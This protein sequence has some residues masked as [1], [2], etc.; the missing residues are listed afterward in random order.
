MEKLKRFLL[1][2]GPGILWATIA[3]GETHLVLLPY[4]GALFG[5]NVLWVVLL[6]HVFYYP[7]F[8]FGPRYAVATGESLIDG[9]GRMKLGKAFNW[10]FLALMLVTPPLMM[11]S[12]VGLTGSALYAGIPALGFNIWCTIACGVTLVIIVSRKY[13]VIERIAKLL[14]FIIVTISLFAFFTSPPSP[15]ELARGLIPNLSA[16]A[17]F[18][19]VLV[20]V[21][22]MPTDPTVSIFLSKWAQE[23]RREWGDDKHVLLNSLNKS[24]TD[25]RTG[26]VISFGVAVVFLAL[27]ATVLR[28]LGIVPQGIE[29]SVKLSEIYT[30]S[31]GR[32]IYPVFIIGALA[33]F[34]GTY[35]SAMDGILRLF[36]NIIGRIFGTEEKKLE[37][38]GSVYTIL[39]A[40]AGLM[41]ATVIKRPVALVLL[42]V[43]MGLFYYP[44]IFGMNIYCVTKLIDKEFRPGKLNLTIAFL[45][46]IL[47]IT[48]L[49]LLILV[50]VLKIFA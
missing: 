41:M 39:M 13:K 31:F 18:M 19:L 16:T 33:A 25:I 30:S 42:A 28:P 26:F 6:V 21:L 5:M 2:L 45:G 24:L 14:T 40:L 12:L 3:I 50:R 10:F 11:G 32:W 44:I 7:N 43:S 36:S 46:L 8:E 4:A 23:K 20:A 17:A 22:R 37:I 29:I 34:W 1:I 9:Y 49:I 35:L 27:G 47:G 15:T 48:A 38:I